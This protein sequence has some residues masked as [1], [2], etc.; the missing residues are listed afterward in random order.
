M[1]NYATMDPA[2]IALIIIPL[3]LLELGLM[4]YAL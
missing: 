4:L 1:A 2:T 3:V